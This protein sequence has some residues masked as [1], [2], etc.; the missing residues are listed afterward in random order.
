MDIFS[1]K[2]LKW[3][4]MIALVFSANH[5]QES[6]MTCFFNISNWIKN[7][8]K[9]FRPKDTAQLLKPTM[10]NQITNVRTMSEIS[11]Y[12]VKS[13]SLRVVKFQGSYLKGSYTD[14]YVF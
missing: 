13:K 1:L 14:V 5:V 6:D 10:V 9:P 7:Y 12:Y 11:W 4:K 8:K 2:N 3:I